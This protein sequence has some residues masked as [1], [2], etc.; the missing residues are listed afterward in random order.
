MKYVE[1]RY[2]NMIIVR[3]AR[4]RDTIL[5]SRHG[6]YYD[7][8]KS[9]PGRSDDFSQR[10]NMRNA[11]KIKCGCYVMAE[12]DF[13]TCGKNWKP[14]PPPRVFGGCSVAPAKPPAPAKI[15]TEEIWHELPETCVTIRI[16]L[17]FDGTGNN[18]SNTAMAEACH[19]STVSQLGQSDADQVAI[20]SHCKHY[21]LDPASSYDNGITNVAR[22]WSLYRDDSKQPYRIKKPYSTV[23]KRYYY[24]PIY[25]DGI[26]TTAGE[27]DSTVPGYAF[28]TGD[29]GMIARVQQ[30]LSQTILKEL[31]GFSQRHHDVFIEALEF[32]IFGFSRGAAAA[33]HC[34]NEINL[35][36]DGPLKR[37]KFYTNAQFKQGFHLSTGVDVN[38][39]GLFDT[40]V[41]RAS[42]ADGFNIRAG[43]TGPLH[44]ALPVDCARQV[45]H[46]H[47]R[48]EHRANFMLTTVRPKH[49]EIALPGVHSDIGGGYNKTKE[50]PLMMIEP[51]RSVETVYQQG[52]ENFTT[53]LHA[54]K[55]WTLAKQQCLLWQEKLHD[56]DHDHLQ[57]DGWT[58]WQEMQTSHADARKARV[59]VAYATVKL[60]RPI[61]P[62]YQLIPLRLMH[63]LALEAQVPL[64]SIPDERAYK[65]PDELEPIAG[66]L[67]AGQS[68]TPEEEA[69]LARKYLHQSAHWN[70][71]SGTE[72]LHL[73]THALH[74]LYPHRP[75][76][77]GKRIVLD[78]L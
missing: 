34:V 32:D 52:G 45:V 76:P 65:L 61:D 7:L 51:L 62:S 12:S 8:R 5:C 26:G 14:D 55:A 72:Y 43:K 56:T 59:P 28:G 44:V 66:K 22:L 4:P 18:A 17:F 41:S 35:R 21:M 68:L 58:A 78:N 53:A 38:F 64:Q 1:G 23:T 39:V 30:T 16:G 2:V 25:I 10:F 48:D 50:G 63:K 47:A 74:L 40:V 31:N 71:G 75:D 42:L 36:E 33:R 3:D 73:E 15:T 46:I 60:E 57:V 11:F 67:L 19:A 69:L 24:V 37:V 49:R 77:T 54:S 6:W 70:F 13:A 27:P 20:A 29:T 9:V